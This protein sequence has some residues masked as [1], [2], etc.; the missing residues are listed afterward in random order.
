[1]HVPGAI[2][3]PGSTEQLRVAEV[4]AGGGS[5]VF[6]LSRAAEEIYAF[7]YD[8]YHGKAAGGLAE[9]KQIRCNDSGAHSYP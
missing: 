3:T 2:M 6:L 8:G 4:F 5:R 1:M 9:L 7:F